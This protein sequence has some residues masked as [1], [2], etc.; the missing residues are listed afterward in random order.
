MHGRHARSFG[1][2]C[3]L[4]MWCLAVP[5]LSAQPTTYV[6]EPNEYIII[7][8]RDYREL[9]VS[10]SDDRQD[11]LIN[12]ILVATQRRAL[13]DTSR[14]F[15]NIEP[16]DYAKAPFVS[17]LVG[18]GV[19]TKDAAIEY[20]SK[21]EE[22]QEIMTDWAVS[23]KA[24]PRKKSEWDAAVRNWL[25]APANQGVVKHC[26]Q[27]AGGYSYSLWTQEH[28]ILITPSLIS[29][30]SPAPSLS[31]KS[32]ASRYVGF[33]QQSKDE[34]LVVIGEGGGGR[35]LTG[36]LHV[37]PAIRQIAQVRQTNDYVSGPFTRRQLVVLGIL[38]GASQ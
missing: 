17:R 6:L 7:A 23:V 38:R 22:F 13:P 11:V 33:F 31:A 29:D 36:N 18:D 26:D 8:G 5:S 34:Q 32:V 30:S 2:V 15:G 37:G 10:E 3:T 19:E 14:A 4:G 35:F 21:A 27:Q 24:D 20:N 12:G 25:A 16:I 28:M 1:A 9:N